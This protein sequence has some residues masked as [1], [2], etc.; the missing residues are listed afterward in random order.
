MPYCT[1]QVPCNSSTLYFTLTLYYMYEGEYPSVYSSLLHIY[2]H[3]QSILFKI[4]TAS[5][6]T[7]AYSRYVHTSNCL[8][9]Y[10]C[11]WLFFCLFSGY[12]GN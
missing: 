8:N 10:D 11:Y 4:E 6:K 7:V 3:F 12:I 5:N 1:K 2:F 9:G